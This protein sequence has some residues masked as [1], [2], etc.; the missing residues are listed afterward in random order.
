MGQERAS[1]PFADPRAPA[2]DERYSAGQAIIAKYALHERT[3][4]GDGPNFSFFS[5][6]FEAGVSR[7]H[8]TTEPPNGGSASE[9]Q[10]SGI[11]PMQEPPE[12][13]AVHMSLARQFWL[14]PPPSQLK[15]QEAPVL[16]CW[17]QLP[18]S[19]DAV[20]SDPAPQF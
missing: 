9:A 11:V 15:L 3:L 4:R 20:Q 17:L 7:R 2:G 12:Q 10:I 8:E 1:Y 5:N 19:Q 18:T 13:V 16:H 6:F 14:Q